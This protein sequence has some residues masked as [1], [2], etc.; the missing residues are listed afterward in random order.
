M[1]N[2]RYIKGKRILPLLPLKYR[3]YNENVS[4]YNRFEVIFMMEDF[5]RKISV[6]NM[7][8]FMSKAAKDKF[9]MD[10]SILAILAFSENN[11]PVIAKRNSII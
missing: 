4:S 11:Q 7:Q 5:I 8:T 6:M 10:V 2:L 3:F 1:F 9:Q